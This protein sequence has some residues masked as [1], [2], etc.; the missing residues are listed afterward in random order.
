[1][2]EIGHAI[3][4]YHEHQRA[5]R[6]NYVELLKDK[7]HPVNYA[8]R[9]EREQHGQYDFYSIMHYP[10]NGELDDGEQIS[11]KHR[12]SRLDVHRVGN[13][14][15]L[16]PGDIAAAKYL[17]EL[18]LQVSRPYR[19]A[20][21]VAASRGYASSS[22]GAGASHKP[23]WQD[24]LEKGDAYFEKKNYD[25][26]LECYQKLLESHARH[27]GKLDKAHLFNSCGVCYFEK[28][29]YD[30]ALESFLEA[31]ELYPKHRIFRNNH[32]ET[33]QKIALQNLSPSRRREALYSEVESQIAEHSVYT[34]LR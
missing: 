33:H 12:F 4:F 32:K 25:E 20:S 1:M 27:F 14:D 17:Y 6:D 18:S 16:S 24:L 29:Q 3:G 28:N 13:S 5:D 15:K 31:R 23:K 10:V 26:A 2:H 11:V 22:L 7:G 21:S 19:Q 34:R 8:K 9:H 30:E